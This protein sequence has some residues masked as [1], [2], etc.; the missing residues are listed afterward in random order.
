MLTSYFFQCVA[1]PGIEPGTSGLWVRRATGCATRPGSKKRI[2]GKSWSCV[3]V[4]FQHVQYICP[5]WH[6]SY[7]SKICPPE[8]S[9]NLHLGYTPPWISPML[10]LECLNTYRKSHVPNP[11]PP[12]IPVFRASKHE[13]ILDTFHVPSPPSFSMTQGSL[14]LL[15]RP[16]GSGNPL[17]SCLRLAHKISPLF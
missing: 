14:P 4:I 2:I 11:S 1:G 8:N 15:S 16:S 10:K 12:S 6:Q 7:N 5:C 3:A 17:G 13:L 9:C